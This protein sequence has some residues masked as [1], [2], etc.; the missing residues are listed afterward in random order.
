MAPPGGPSEASFLCERKKS[1]VATVHIVI[2][3]V[4][5]SCALSQ[6]WEQYVPLKPQYKFA[7]VT[8]PITSWPLCEYHEG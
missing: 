6:R 2:F 5:S 4:M 3:L 1:R 8:E 7:T